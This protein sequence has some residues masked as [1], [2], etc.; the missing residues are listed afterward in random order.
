[1]PAVGTLA[2]HAARACLREVTP[3]YL[4][5]P[6][7][8]CRATP[9]TREVELAVRRSRRRCLEI[10]RSVGHPRRVGQAGHCAA[11]NGESTVTASSNP[12]AKCQP[13]AHTHLRENRP[14]V[15]QKPSPARDYNIGV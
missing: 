7:R 12:A 2:R 14:Q 9:E 10:E 5:L 3:S 8:A 4:S 15:R 1:V 13:A 11:A 6:Q